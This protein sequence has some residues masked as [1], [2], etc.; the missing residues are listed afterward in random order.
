MSVCEVIQSRNFKNFIIDILVANEREIILFDSNN[1]K[2]YLNGSFTNF[3]KADNM[4]SSVATLV[5]SKMEF[6]IN[7]LSQFN[8][9]TKL[10]ACS[11]NI[12][13]V[14][15]LEKT[16]LAEIIMCNNKISQIFKI[17]DSLEY[18]DLSH[19]NIS[20]IENLSNKPNLKSVNLS[21]NNIDVIC[22]LENTPL[23]YLNM[24]ANPL[25][26]AKTSTIHDKNIFIQYGPLSTKYNDNGY[27]TQIL[28]EISLHN[29]IKN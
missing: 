5:V 21:Y 17:P 11:C 22:N 19:N 28:Q 23:D 1:N 14:N 18:L 10:S 12:T 8:N 15:N 27:I 6:D 16:N 29:S 20:K 9:L 24:I 3:G 2:I 13:D 25:L 26:I 4:F 7:I